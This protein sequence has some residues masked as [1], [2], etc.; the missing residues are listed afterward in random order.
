MEQI[1]VFLADDHLVVREG[2]KALIMA[3]PDM[4]LIGEDDDG[5]AAWQQASDC[6]PDVVIDVNIIGDIARKML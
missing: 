4:T 2:L 5:Q 6:R 3:Q 1:Q